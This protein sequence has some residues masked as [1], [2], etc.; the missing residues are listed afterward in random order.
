LESITLGHPLLD[1]YLAFVAVRGADQHVVGGGIGFEDLL[2]RGRQG[3]DTGDAGGCVG[4]LGHSARS[5]SR[6]AGSSASSFLQ[7]DRGCVLER[8]GEKKRYRYRFRDPLMQPF[9]VLA[10]IANKLIPEEYQRELFD[11]DDT[12]A[13]WEGVMSQLTLDELELE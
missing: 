3:A 12:D 1:D 2:R 7:P 9:A 4:V 8:R 6:C 10:A 11:A 5:S 13:D